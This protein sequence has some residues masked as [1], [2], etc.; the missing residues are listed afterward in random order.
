MYKLEPGDK[1]DHESNIL[2]HTPPGTGRKLGEGLGLNPGQRIKV[3]PILSTIPRAGWLQLTLGSTA[4][5]IGIKE[6]KWFERDTEHLQTA[7]VGP[8]GEGQGLEER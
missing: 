8:S 3:E 1:E 7:E 2:P 6:L 5:D 4:L